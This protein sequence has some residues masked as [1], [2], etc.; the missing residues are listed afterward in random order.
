MSWRMSFEWENKDLQAPEKP[1][2]SVGKS[3]E[4]NKLRQG[5]KYTEEN[6]G[7]FLT[8]YGVLLLQK[9][10]RFPVPRQADQ[11]KTHYWTCLDSTE[12]LESLDL[13][14][15]ELNAAAW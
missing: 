13:K 5:K 2:G 11:E 12:R 6:T 10:S 1:N 7:I 8:G 4:V 15:W 3:R 9:I 14:C